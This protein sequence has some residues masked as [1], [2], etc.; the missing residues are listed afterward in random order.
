[1]LNYHRKKIERLTLTWEAGD[2][3]RYDRGLA[4]AMRYCK[5]R[6]YRVVFV[7]TLKYQDRAKLIAE[8]KI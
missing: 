6:G 2:P 1:M 8:R 7:S 5:T 4:A 3:I